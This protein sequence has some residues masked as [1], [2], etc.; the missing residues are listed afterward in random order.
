M[1]SSFVY[2]DSFTDPKVVFVRQ[3][4]KLAFVLPYVVRA[5]S[6]RLISLSLCGLRENRLIFVTL[7]GI[8]NSLLN[9]KA[10]PI[11]DSFCSPN[12]PARLTRAS[13]SLGKPIRTVTEV[14]CFQQLSLSF[15]SSGNADTVFDEQTGRVALCLE[16]IN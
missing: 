1:T 12:T 10:V 2:L 13:L 16:F 8:S 11:L 14:G 5:Q 15:V 4:G 9:S 7:E 6:V 3:T